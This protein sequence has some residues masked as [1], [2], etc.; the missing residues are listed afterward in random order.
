M[1]ENV[2]WFLVSW[3]QGGDCIGQVGDGDESSSLLFTALDFYSLLS[4]GDKRNDFRTRGYQ[5][6]T[7]EV[8]PTR[9][10][11]SH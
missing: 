10:R 11:H 8:L 1:A 3:C 5:L 9:R 4:S 7:N 2:S 6:E